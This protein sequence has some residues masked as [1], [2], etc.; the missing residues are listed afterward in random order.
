MGP[1]PATRRHRGRESRSEGSLLPYP[2]RAA[3]RP[4]ASLGGER[5]GGRPST[6]VS[7][8]SRAAPGS[9]G[10]TPGTRARSL[11]PRRVERAASPPIRAVRARRFSA[12]N[13]VLARR[14]VRLLVGV[15]ADE[16]AW[17]SDPSGESST[18]KSC[19]L[20]GTPLSGCNSRSANAIPEPATRSETAR[21]FCAAFGRRCSRLAVEF[22]GLLVAMMD[23]S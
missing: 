13:V 16:I 4:L 21:A 2:P 1:P 19:Y 5:E 12:A 7:R 14:S 6:G 18:A 17:R 20:L 3:L 10:T 23:G 8:L 11:C 9:T 15:L 22:A